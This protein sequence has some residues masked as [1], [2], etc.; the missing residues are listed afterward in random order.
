ML[1]LMLAAAA[2]GSLHTLAPDHWMPFAALA[3][4]RNWALALVP[5]DAYG[6]V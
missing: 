6:L 5:A 2:V 3:R 4:A 1:A